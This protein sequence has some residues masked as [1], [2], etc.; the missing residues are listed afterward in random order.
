MQNPSQN[1]RIRAVA[2]YDHLSALRLALPVRYLD[3]TRDVLNNESSVEHHARLICALHLHAAR[4]M[5]CFTLDTSNTETELLQCWEINL[6]YCE[7][8][9]TIVKEW[10]SQF[11]STVDPAICFIIFYALVLVQLHS[12]KFDLN[13]HPEL[14]GRLASYKNVLLLFLQQFASAWKFP[15]LLISMRLSEVLLT[16]S[17]I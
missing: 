14:E 15:Q 7:D 11:G 1:L 9:V 12:L 5:V 4:M 2:L 16:E 10:D 13:S 8:I 6:Q 3:P 17:F